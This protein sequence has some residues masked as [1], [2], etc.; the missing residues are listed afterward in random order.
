ML[1]MRH[2]QI[3][4]DNPT[5]ASLLP[6]SAAPA[7][8]IGRGRPGVHII[9][10]PSERNQCVIPVEGRLEAD[11][12]LLLEFDP[13]IR[14]YRSQ[15]L[16][17]RLEDE[18]GP[19]NH[20]PD[21]E[22][23]PTEGRAY[24]LE[25]KPHARASQAFRARR[26]EVARQHFL[27]MDLDYVLRTEHH[28]RIEP[29]ITTLRNLYGRARTV[30][31]EALAELLIFLPTDGSPVPLKEIARQMPSNLGH[32]GRGLLEGWVDAEVDKPIGPNWFVWRRPR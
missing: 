17:V 25:V 32:I 22:V 12:C 8:K 19:F 6:Q 21:F 27:G 5:T 11:M 18:H 24:L 13:S 28:I 15:P 14:S 1:E 2:D 31:R 23:Q 20:T 26:I 7:R 29:R 16:T 3:A 9:Q 10:F 30:R 4:T